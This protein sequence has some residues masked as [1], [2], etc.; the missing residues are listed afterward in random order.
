METNKHAFVQQWAALKPNIQRY[1]MAVVKNTDDAADIVQE[2]FIKAYANIHTLK[3]SEKLP[4]W[5]YSIARNEVNAHFNHQKKNRQIVVEEADSSPATTHS[6]ERCIDSFINALPQKYRQAVQLAEIENL[7]QTQLANRLNIS[8][9]GAKTR[10]Q[11]GRQKLKELM[12]QCCHI[13]HD[14]YGNIVDYT[15]K[16]NGHCATHCA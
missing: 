13:Q 12:T 5:L 8:Y 11:R 3:N 16:P 4:Q 7:P 15:P 2:V 14:V 10:V 6:F 9:S 1:V